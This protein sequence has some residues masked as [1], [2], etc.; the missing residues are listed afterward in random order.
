MNVSLLLILGSL[1]ESATNLDLDISEWFLLIC[2]FVL[3]IGIFGEYG[4]LPKR[5]FTWSTATFATLVMVAIAGEFFGDAGVFVF[6]RH[7]QKLEGA[8]IQTL[9]QK[10]EVALANANDADN[11]A[12]SAVALLDTAR[13]DSDVAKQSAGR[14]QTLARQARK[15]ADSFEND[16]LTAKEHAASAESHLADALK[17]AADAT[18]ELQRLEAS[19]SVINTSGLVSAL[20]P[21][22]N[23]EYTFVSVFADEESIQLLRSIDDVLQR[24]GWKRMKPPRGFPAINVFGLDQDYAVTSSLTTGLKIS[25][26][27]TES[28]T[29]LQSLPLDKMPQ[30]VRAAITLNLNLSANLSPQQKTDAV[31]VQSGKSSTIRITVGKKP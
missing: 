23:T 18:A 21:F 13:R 20:E 31:D 19:R 24:A 16:I 15:E 30:L 5:L 1:S 4:K 11:Q 6:S 29:A 14:A 2:G 9:S 28:L 22:K 8:D 25:V 7:L 27:S 3:V 10:S 17:Q 26:D 12:K